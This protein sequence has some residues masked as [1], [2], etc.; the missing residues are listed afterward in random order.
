[1]LAPQNCT[2]GRKD[3]EEE[4]HGRADQDQAG[5]D[6][7]GHEGANGHCPHIDLCDDNRIKPRHL[8][9]PFPRRA[10]TVGAATAVA[11]LNTLL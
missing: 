4:Q 9:L 8:S 7:G 10:L 6:H 1:M 5:D 2:N 11:L 3:V